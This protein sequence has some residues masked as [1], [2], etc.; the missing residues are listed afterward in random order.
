VKYLAAAWAGVCLASTG[1]AVGETTVQG[2][3]ASFAHQYASQTAVDLVKD[4]IQVETE[5]AVLRWM[6]N[7]FQPPGSRFES[8]YRCRFE[9]VSPR[10]EHTVSVSLY[11][12]ETRDFAEHTQWKDLQIIPIEHV[13]DEANG[14]A[15]YGV[16]KYLRPD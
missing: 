13:V 11:L 15:G 14:H 16:F 2:Y 4:S 7:L 9:T 5:P 10:K 8:G 3:C 12:A 1:M 6:S